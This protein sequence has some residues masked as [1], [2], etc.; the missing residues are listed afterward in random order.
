M[1]IIIKLCNVQR[2]GKGSTW[3][4]VGLELKT[5]HITMTEMSL[6]HVYLKVL[7]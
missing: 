1:D 5:T 6:L 2:L 3:S 4:N 7:K